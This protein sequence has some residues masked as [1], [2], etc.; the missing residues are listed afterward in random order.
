MSGRILLVIVMVLTAGFIGYAAGRIETREPMLR[1]KV[2]RVA[3]EDAFTLSGTKA[4]F[5]VLTHEVRVN[6]TLPGD[7]GQPGDEL[8]L[9]DPRYSSASTTCP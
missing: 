2:A 9:P 1:F 8:F 3:Y 7:L 4:P 5:T 6:M